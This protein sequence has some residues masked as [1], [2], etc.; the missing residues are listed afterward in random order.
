MKFPHNPCWDFALVVYRRAGVEE[1]CLALQERHGIDVNVLLFCCWLGQSGRGALSG[2]EMARTLAAVKQWHGAVVGGLRAVR[3]VLKG[4]LGTAPREL[5]D[6]LR[7]QV[8]ACELDAEHVQQIMLCAAVERS[9]PAARPSI[10]RRAGDAAIN[11]ARYFAALGVAVTE[12]E[13]SEL[14]VVLGASFP[15]LDREKVAALCGSLGAPDM[16]L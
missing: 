4:G 1:A 13:I 15:E 8:L 2:G 11:V 10:E 12:R 14:E 16:C 9:E 7:R 6:A 5:G 3:G